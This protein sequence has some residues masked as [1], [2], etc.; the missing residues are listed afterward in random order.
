VLRSRPSSAARLTAIAIAASP[1]VP[2]RSQELPSPL[3]GFFATSTGSGAAGGNLGGLEGADLK[4]ATLAAAADLPGS[5]WAAYLSTSTANARDRIGCGPWYNVT[6]TL[7]ATDVD[8]LHANGIPAADVLDENGAAIPF[9]AHDILTG[10]GQ[11]GGLHP[12]GANCGDFQVSEASSYVAVGH[13][14]GGGVGEGGIDGNS[15]SISW[16]AA[17]LSACSQAGLQATS[18]EGRIYCFRVDVPNLIFADGFESGV[19]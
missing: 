5:T 9:S 12:T 13:S 17:H 15:I 6:G 11:A 3:S 1:L 4:C 10:S 14:D 18:G 8:D 19:D 7:I 2:A 16:N